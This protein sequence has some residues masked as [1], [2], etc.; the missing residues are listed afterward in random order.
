MNKL[1][2]FISIVLLS[3]IIL[4]IVFIIFTQTPV[5]KTWLKNK[6]VTWAQSYLN[7]QI[8]LK[9]LKGN[10]FTYFQLEDFSIQLG[11]EPI[12]KVKRAF[13]HYRPF[14]LFLKKLSF[15][16][17][18]L[19]APELK[20]IQQDD[21]IW[22]LAKLLKSTGT[23]PKADRQNLSKFNWKIELPKIHIYS[24]AAE[25]KRAKIAQWD[26]PKRIKNLAVNLGLWYSAGKAR[27]SLEQLSFDTE[28]PDFKVQ[29]IHCN[30]KFTSDSLEAKDFEIETESS[31]FTS[32]LG[33]KNFKNPILHFSIKGHP[34][35]LAEIRKAVPVL[36]LYG[37]PRLDLEV[38]GPLN[39][40]DVECNL[41]LGSG[42]IKVSGNLQVKELP[43]RYDL[44]GIVS[45]FNL[46]EITNESKLASNLNFDFS[47]QGKNITW[48]EIDAQ[49]AC[50]FD[51]S[52]AM[53]KSFGKS[54]LDLEVRGDSLNFRIEALV[55]E[56]CAD[57]SGMFISANR[58][59]V[60]EVKGKIQDLNLGAFL[61]SNRVTSDFDLDFAL[62]GLGWNNGTM[63]GNLTL[64]CLPSYINQIPIDSAYF[65]FQL[66]NQKLNLK[67]FTISSPLGKILAE[68]EVSIEKGND[69]A[70]DANFVDFS[71]LSEA[72]PIDSLWGRGNFSG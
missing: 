16:E 19:E 46:A 27:L 3:L 35:S 39:D 59:P 10:L 9:A 34:I 31:K 43:Y 2:K 1:V 40:L 49:I 61:K 68:G 22:N 33:V 13:V 23:A 20:M 70:L 50:K 38:Q 64:Q 21:Q 5:F 30:V 55:E 37:N 41:W 8:E 54:K 36:K 58:T 71:V 4:G 60:Y 7:G 57:F 56:A 12:I 62:N 24:A 6:A 42:K 44:T 72:L 52:K 17:I 67:A 51:S 66:E 15:R 11:E 28:E 53:G 45:N 14:A 18:I 29:T 47:V 48:R 63:S 32:N 69:L 65:D 25:L 26:L